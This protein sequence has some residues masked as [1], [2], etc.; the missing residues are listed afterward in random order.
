MKAPAALPALRHTRAGDAA[1]FIISSFGRPALLPQLLAKFLAGEPPIRL[2]FRFL[3]ASPH[4]GS[5]M[6]AARDDATT[7]PA[8][9]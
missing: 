8:H 5:A 2:T 4:Y 1:I 3:D 7:M 6:P 9:Y